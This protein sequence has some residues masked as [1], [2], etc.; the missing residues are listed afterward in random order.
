MFY[1]M[2]NQELH[3]WSLKQANPTI[4]IVARGLRILLKSQKVQTFAFFKFAQH[5]QLKVE[6][7]YVNPR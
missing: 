4:G 5:Q 1:L 6:F 7:L 3:I 2:N